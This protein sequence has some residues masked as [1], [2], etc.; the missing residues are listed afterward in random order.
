MINFSTINN[1]KPLGIT[2]SGLV[3]AAAELLRIG[4]I[5]RS[6]KFNPD[7]KLFQERM[8]A[9]RDNPEFVLVEGKSTQTSQPITITQKDIRE[10]QLAKAAIYAGIQILL[11]ELGIKSEEITE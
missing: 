3:D 11:E 6:G 4:I 8:V 7:L 2:G 10:L 5:D 1:T 9:G